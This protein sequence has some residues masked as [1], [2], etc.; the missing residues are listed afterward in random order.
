MVDIEYHELQN[1]VF[2]ISKAKRNE[3]FYRKDELEIS[4]FTEWSVVVLFYAA[5]HYIDAVLSQ[6]TSLSPEYRDPIDHSTRNIAVTKCLNLFPIAR[7]YLQLYR[8]SIEAR[9]NQLTF[10]DNY[11]TNAKTNLFNPIQKQSRTVL[12][13]TLE[14]ESS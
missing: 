10:P 7:E 4:N 12:G 5:V 9:Y 8:R 3:R 13:I 11:G 2:H 1:K 14:T 6:D